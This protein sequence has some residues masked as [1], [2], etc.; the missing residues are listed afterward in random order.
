MP[1][2]TREEKIRIKMDKN[3]DI[4][5][6]I[7][8]T[9]AENTPASAATEPTEISIPPKIITYVRPVAKSALIA[10]CEV[11]FIIFFVVKKVSVL[12]PN[13]THRMTKNTITIFFFSHA[14]TFSILYTSQ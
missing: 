1:P 3:T 8:P 13:P 7:K 12:T 5:G 10:I 9:I 11:K 6:N 14:F 4:S 2:M